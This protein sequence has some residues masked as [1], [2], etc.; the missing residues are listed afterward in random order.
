MKK[1]KWLKISLGLLSILVVINL[2]ASHYFY[3]LAIKR[4]QKDFLVDNEDLVVSATAMDVFL[5]GG[6]RDWVSSQ[7]FD[8]WELESYDGLTLQGYYLEA[9]EPSNQTVVL[10][11]GY[12]GRATDMGLFGQ[13]YYEDLG[14]NIFMPDLRGHG[15]SEGDYIG[16]GWHDRLDI[17]D[18]VDQIIEHQGDDTEVVLHGISMGSATVL[19]AS[20]E[21]LSDNVKAIIADSPYTDTYSLF[22]YQMNRMFNL[23][24]FPLLPSTSL[25]TQYRA[26][27]SLTEASSLDQV[28]QTDVPILYFHGNNDT[29]VPTRMA[30]ELHE[31]TNSESEIM[32][33][34]NAGHG[35]AIAVYPEQYVDHLDRFL[36]KYLK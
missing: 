32:V 3:D 8:E 29:F 2:V 11:H 5:Q 19:M 25:M 34:E 13:H 14:Y 31:N 4:D 22:K 10:A 35:E 23:P 21:D 24:A 26:G 28:K 33:F 27:Y 30:E 7:P 17:L 36:E 12:L 20:G 16:F 18:W 1:K 15:N 9:K 6:W